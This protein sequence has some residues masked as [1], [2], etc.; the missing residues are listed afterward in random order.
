M[1]L[2]LPLLS[3]TSSVLFGENRFGGRAEHSQFGAKRSELQ[4]LPQV[5]LIASHL[6]KLVACIWPT[7]PGRALLVAMP[8]PV[9]VLLENR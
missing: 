7:A 6:T 9:G 4:S 2:L 1:M 5:K 8:R 3:D